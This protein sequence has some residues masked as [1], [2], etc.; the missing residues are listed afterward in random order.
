MASSIKTVTDRAKLKPRREPYWEAVR[1][2][3]YIGFRKITSGTE[4][5]WVARW[6]D[7]GTG[8]QR[9]QSLGSFDELPPN[10]RRDAA[11]TAA[12]SWF[13]HVG[14]GGRLD[15]MTVDAAC[16]AYVD[17]VRSTKAADDAEGRF[18][19]WVYGD[20]KL[21]PVEL[22]KLQ[23]QHLLAWRKRLSAAPVMLQRE[24]TDD[25]EPQARA[26]AT[27]NRDMSALR[28]ALNYAR[29][30]GAV[31]TDGAWSEALKPLKNA[32]SRR[33][34]Y[35]DREQ[36]Q[37]WLQQAAPD[38][39]FLL[40]AL[41]LIPLRPGALAGL[42]V[43]D[44]DKRLGTLRVGKDKAGGDRHIA[45]PPATAAFF[46]E[47]TDHALPTAPL[48]RRADGQ[49]WDKDAWKGPVKDAALSA[50]LPSGTTA[51]TLRHC[52]ITDLVV[53]GLDL[54]TVAQLSG[55]SVAMIEK[56]YGHLR[57]EHAR[58]ALAALAM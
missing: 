4:G 2:G 56:H 30:V 33:T 41:S 10:E 5:T 36:R 14:A 22:V 15:S 57:A 54:L 42:N 13:R 28:A 43:G 1:R 12:E 18:K 52:V 7:P 38:V 3:C 19:R 58:Q 20:T 32:D 46:A 25:D 34:I 51:Y 35:L 55:T 44:F 37:K 39:A 21:A 45:L 48:L 17:H 49:R 27:I 53:A 8:G 11:S 40:R 31:M 50:G 16:R 6:R 24:A 47:R 23:P 29:T 26:R 9:Y